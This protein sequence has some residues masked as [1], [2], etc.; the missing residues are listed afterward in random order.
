MVRS[1][2]PGERLAKV[3]EEQDHAIEK[4]ILKREMFKR[5]M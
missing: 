5:I 3:I 2:E 1:K 4:E